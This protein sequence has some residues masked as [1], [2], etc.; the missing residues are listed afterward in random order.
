MK[1]TAHIL[2]TTFLLVGFS[3]V[4]MAQSTD[5]A[6]ITANANVVQNMVV[7]GETKDLEFNNILIGSGKFIDAVD[8]SADA[9]TA[10][11]EIIGAAVNG[12]TS[13]E[14]RGYFSIEIA[15][16]ITVDLSL[17][18]PDELKDDEDNGLFVHFSINND[19]LNGLLSTTK[20]EGTTS[21]TAITNGE[22]SNFAIFGGGPNQ[23]NMRDPFTMPAGGKVYLSLG[24]T[25][26][27]L[28]NQALSTYTG[29]LTLT[30]TVVED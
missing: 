14:S 5:N 12:I 2:I 24:G 4:T 30:A 23:W 16:G 7:G 3:S 10:N 26:V 27:A 15:E 8:G 13:G 17:D 11:S 19:E 20:P 1:V 9:A 25:V 22:S 18:E 21:V 6:T 29:T 28:N